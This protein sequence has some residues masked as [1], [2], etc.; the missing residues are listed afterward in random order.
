MA[1]Q[2]LLTDTK[3]RRYVLKEVAFTMQHNDNVGEQNAV[4]ETGPLPLVYT[5]PLTFADAEDAATQLAAEHP[6][7]VVQ[8][9]GCALGV[10]QAAASVLTNALRRYAD[11]GLLIVTPP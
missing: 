4:T 10:E 5:T 6:Q 7:R 2:S 3:V 1:V 8:L 9:S 11:A